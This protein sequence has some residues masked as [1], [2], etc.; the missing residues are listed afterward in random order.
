MN[1]KYKYILLEIFIFHIIYIL[2]I[3]HIFFLIKLYN[4]IYY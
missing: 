2:Y 1:N 3:L 4:V